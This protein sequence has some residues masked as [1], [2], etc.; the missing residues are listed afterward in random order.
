MEG[1]LD[2]LS[3]V[4]GGALGPFDH[5]TTMTGK[6]VTENTASLT[7]RQAT[8]GFTPRVRQISLL[9]QKCADVPTS[10]IALRHRSVAWPGA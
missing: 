5:L 2:H 9:K 8:S 7:A 6:T 10:E 3:P 1:C 4:G